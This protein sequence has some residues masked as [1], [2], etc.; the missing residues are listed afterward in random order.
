LPP[1]TY[2]VAFRA[3]GYAPKSARVTIGDQDIILDVSM[4]AALVEL[5]A[6]QVTATPNAGSALSSPQPTAV[7]AGD[8]LRTNQAA[9]LGATIATTPGVRSWETGVGI[10]KPVIRG[11]T[12]NRVLVL[13][14][15]Q[16]TETQSWADEHSPNVEVAAAD[17]IELIKGPASVLYGSDALGGVVNVI[18]SDLPDAIGRAPM[19]RARFSAAFGTN[20]R[21]PDATVLLEGA[22]GGFGWRASLTGRTSDDVRTARGTLANSGNEAL[23]GSATAGF[24]GGWGS[25]VATYT[26]RNERIQLL[27]EDP[28]ATPFQRVTDNRARIALTLPAGDAARIEAILGFQRNNRRE[29][30]DRND[31]EADVDAGLRSTAWTGDLHFHHAPIGRMVGIIGAQAFVNDLTRFGPEKLI[32]ESDLWNV[33]LFAFEQVDLDR[34]NLSFGVRYDHRTLDVK[35]GTVGRDTRAR[36]VAAQTRTFNSLVGNVGVLYRIAEPAALVLNVGRG[37]RAPSTFDLFA[38]GVHEGTQQFL[39]GQPDLKNETSLNTDLA[40]RVQSGMVSL[41]VGGYVNTI[42]NFIYPLPTSQFDDNPADP[43]ASGLREYVVTHGN[44]RFWGFEGSVDWHPI[45]A[46]EFQGGLDYVRAQNRS[47]DQPLPWI[48]PFRATYS[49]KLLGK[50]GKWYQRPYLQ[51]GGESNAKQT[52]IDPNELAPGTPVPPGYTLVNIGAGARIPTGR[53]ALNVDLQLRNAL[54]T[55]YTNWLNRYREFT[56]FD[57]NLGMGRNLVIRVGTDF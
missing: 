16:R 13:D 27:D 53:A 41:E 10:G 8:A 1:G 5:P 20:N 30:A 7:V 28:A 18:P 35:A 55:S 40:L 48:P 46:V 3:I 9:S 26:Q 29:F 56:A 2:L 23:G 21:N 34:W 32:P 49:V 33:G 36:T 50:D 11:L 12:S 45:P 44:A 43:E 51:V 38:F 57:R 47:L 24:R 17:R 14:G 6:I 4:Q 39:I 22:N 31:T 52:R 15:G 19:L 37:F 25:V 42:S 54:N